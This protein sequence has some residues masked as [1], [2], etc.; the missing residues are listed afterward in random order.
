MNNLITTF[1]GMVVA[2]MV[3]FNGILSGYTNLY[4]SNALIH[5][6]GL[7]TIIVLLVVGKH[8][9]KGLRTVPLILY[10]GGLVGVVTVLLTNASFTSLGVSLT[11]ALGQV[12]QFLA[13]V[14][15]D[16]YGMFGLKKVPFNKKKIVGFVIISLGLIIMMFD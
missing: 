8:K 5:G 9:I 6:I 11:L 16:H 15:I 13:S 7:L 3:F 14:V 10:T 12:G 1:I 2:L 4:F